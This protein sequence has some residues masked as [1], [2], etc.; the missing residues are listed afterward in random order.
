MISSTSTD[1]PI[2]DIDTY[3]QVDVLLF[4]TPLAA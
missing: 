3:E 2:M 4:C 1:T